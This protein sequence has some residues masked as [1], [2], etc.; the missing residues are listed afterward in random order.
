MNPDEAR[1]LVGGYATGSLSDSERKAL[2]AAALDDQELFDELADEQSLKELLDEPG[3]RDRLIARLAPK[4]EKQRWSWPWVGVA[5]AL[6][7]VAVI[8]IVWLNVPQPQVANEISAK[9]DVP[10]PVVAPPTGVLS[11]PTSKP[12]RA[13]SA[14]TAAAAASRDPAQNQAK[15][16]T[17]K[18]AKPAENGPVAL[19]ATNSPVASARRDIVPG[20]APVMKAEQA[21]TATAEL[22][23]P[24]LAPPPALQKAR[25]A[26]APAAAA[27]PNRLEQTGQLP[28]LAI[29][30][31][32]AARTGF[33]AG[34]GGGGWRGGF[35]QQQTF[36]FRYQVNDA[37]LQVTPTSIGWLTVTTAD[38]VPVTLLTNRTVPSGVPLTIMVPADAKVLIIQFSIQAGPVNDPPE[39]RVALSGV[40]TSPNASG[41]SITI[42]ARP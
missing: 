1:K 15:N 19:A 33:A 24:V 27:T 26:T 40:V 8:A 37:V 16:Q 34:P 36:G 38:L 7:G 22:A 29:G 12:E 39:R 5:S 28:V 14:P 10:S 42:P 35:V 9:V 23:Q 17:E 21:A 31:A 25:I 6:V 13:P 32:D 4:A 30:A 18:Q 2:F 20:Q 41:V 11:E 3:V